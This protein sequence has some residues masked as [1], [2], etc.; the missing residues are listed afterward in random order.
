MAVSP[1]AEPSSTW[2]TPDPSFSPGAPIARSAMPSPVRSPTAS[3]APNTSPGSC[4]LAIPVVFW[5][6]YWEAA[7]D[8]PLA[9]PRRHVHRARSGVLARRRHG[10]IGEAVAVEVALHRGRRRPSGPAGAE[11]GMVPARSAWPPLLP[12]SAQ[13]TGLLPPTHSLAGVM[14]KP[15]LLRLAMPMGRL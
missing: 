1:D 12:S 7:A 11:Q 13:K 2:T 8:R 10:E 4:E 14:V 3:D 5:V 6:K 9:E 15:S